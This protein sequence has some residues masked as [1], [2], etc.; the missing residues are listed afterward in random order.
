MADNYTF[1]VFEIIPLERIL[2]DKGQNDI[3]T[4]AEVLNTI[5][6]RRKR[7][8][9]KALL[10]E[11]AE[12]DRLQHIAQE[13]LGGNEYDYAWLVSDF[14]EDLMTLPGKHDILFALATT[15][16]LTMQTPHGVAAWAAATELGWALFPPTIPRILFAEALLQSGH[17]DIGNA[18]NCRTNMHRESSLSGDIHLVGWPRLKPESRRRS[19]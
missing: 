14:F 17:L 13:S 8:R 11:I 2:L 4:L 15:K 3:S 18:V 6:Y 1:F 9:S 7:F 19:F 5:G 10:F 12:K 16:P